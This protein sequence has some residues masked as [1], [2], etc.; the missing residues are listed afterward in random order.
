MD[1]GDSMEIRRAR[2]PSWGIA[3]LITLLVCALSILFAWLYKTAWS[4]G[5]FGEYRRVELNGNQEIQTVGNGF[6]YYNG[7]SLSLVSD[8]GDAKWT[9]MIGANVSFDAS[10]SGVA[11]WSGET[12]TILDLENGTPT[13]SSPMGGEVLSAF[14]GPKYTAALLGPEHDSTISILEN[15]GRQV[16]EI[17]LPDQ[18]V[19][20]YGFFSGGTLFWVMTLDTSGTVPTCSIATYKPGKMIVGSISDSEQLMYQ[21]MFQSSQVC[22]A[23]TTHLKVY[24]YT[25]TEQTSKRTLIYGWYLAALDEGADDPMLALVPDAQY[26]GSDTMRDVRM[27]RSNL[28]Q[29][30]RMPFGCATLVAKENNVYGFSNEGYV[31]VAR[32]GEKT[33]AAYDLG[34]PTGTV[35]GVTDNRV[36]VIGSGNTVYLVTLP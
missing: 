4:S 25:G 21:V 31:M 18:T 33:V 16:D 29:V 36:A 35:Y 10:N 22:V 26:G 6:V 9:Y 12:L 30:V 28:D 23:G 34:L 2:K 20:D 19:L 7:S 27:I 32:A 3:V 24:D 17:A 5:T 14:V 8:Q 11:A 15:E 1:Q 13:Y